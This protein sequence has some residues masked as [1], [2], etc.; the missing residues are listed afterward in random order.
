[1]ADKKQLVESQKT[2]PDTLEDV[3]SWL[4]ELAL[5]DQ[6]SASPPPVV[7]VT[8]MMDEDEG[9]SWLDQIADGPRDLLDE[10]PT[11]SWDETRPIHDVL[12]P[13]LPLTSAEE[14][15]EASMD[16][17]INWLDEL[18][19]HT[20]A[21]ADIEPEP[22][23][24]PE[25]EPVV[26]E[27]D[28]AALMAEALAEESPPAPEPIPAPPPPPAPAKKKASMF[29]DDDVF[30][31]TDEELAHAVATGAQVEGFDMPDDDEAA[32][33]WLEG[34]LGDDGGDLFGGLGTAEPEPEAIPEPEP[35]PV[36]EEV[37]LAALMA[38]A[39]AEEPA[40]EPE[41]IPAPPPPAPA[42][43]KASMFGPDEPFS[44]T[45]EELA[46]AVATGAQVEGFDM[47]DDD[48]AA[49][50]WLEG[51]LGDDGGDLFGGLGTAEVEPE[52]LPE[53]EPEPVVAEVDLAALMAE[54]LAEEPAPE[55]EPTP[56]PPPPA[57]AP[58]QKKASMFGPDEPFSVTDEELAHAVATGAQVEGFDMPD[59]DDAAM[60]WLEGL[61]GDD[62]GDLFGG[63]GTAEPEP[64]QSQNQNQN[65]NPFLTLSQR[66]IWGWILM[67]KG[68]TS[69]G[70]MIWRMSRWPKT[71]RA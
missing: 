32:L 7:P 19:A 43:K 59:D 17:A 16:A 57:P 56:A 26:E 10:P 29:G 44:V 18:A 13:S 20:P 12:S 24:E 62:G 60:A 69:R 5:D 2:T 53:P 15:E 33:A 68:A 61:L 23:P 66:W 6:P 46:H 37:D 49:M 64:N 45:D 38:E 36:V 25:P 35:E 27:V 41:P 51:L 34:L 70:W 3:L 65:Q 4:E 50:A 42:K 63:L 1:M 22:I 9:L 67:G 28:L 40:P 39:L 21:T 48:E 8:S 52:P 14:S 54:A 58:A 71:S 55:P 47:P 11:L 31:I 30:S